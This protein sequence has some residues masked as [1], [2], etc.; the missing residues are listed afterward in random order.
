MDLPIV[1]ITPT[2][3]IFVSA[4]VLLFCCVW[5]QQVKRPTQLWEQ[6]L[7][8]ELQAARASAAASRGTVLDR[9][10]FSAM[11]GGAGR[12]TPPP[13]QDLD[14]PTPSKLFASRSQTGIVTSTERGGSRALG[15]H[16][17]HLVA[18][19]ADAHRRASDDKKREVA[20][21]STGVGE[22][23]PNSHSQEQD[24][25]Y[26]LD[27]EDSQLS[28]ASSR[29]ESLYGNFQVLM[30]RNCDRMFSSSLELEEHAVDCIEHE[31]H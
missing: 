29:S 9:R 2:H 28:V 17:G 30:C 16:L 13:V 22:A 31:M 25:N 7:L 1:Y 18:A 24:N 3:D 12:H 5:H 11:E 10:A 8:D 20:S 23:W 21:R 4:I 26:Q 15:G 14:K 19:I 6:R 27:R